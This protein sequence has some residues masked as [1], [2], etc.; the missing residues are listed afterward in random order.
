[1]AVKVCF[2]GGAR[3]GQPVDATSEKKFKAI[4]SLGEVFIIG[5]S[6][7][8]WPR[9]F[10]EHAHFYLLPKLPLPVLRYIEMSFVGPLLACWLILWHGVQVLVAQS[11]YEGFAAAV[12]KKIACCL[13]YKVVLVVE[14]HGDF[15]ESMLLQRS[16]AFVGLY[17]FLMRH[18]ARFS[19]KHADLLRAVSNSTQEQLGRQSP[20]KLIIRFPAWTDIEVFLQ[21]GINREKSSSQNILYA[22]VLTPLKGVHYLINA[23]AL[24]AKDFP[25]ARLFIVGHE[26]NKSYAAE[27]KEQVT[28]FG[29]DARV[30]FMGAMPQAEL[31]MWMRK[32]CVFVLPSVSEGLGRVVMEAMAT[33]TPVIGS[34]VGGIPDVVKD[35]ATGF[36]VRPGDEKVLTEKIQWVL[37]YPDKTQEMGHHARAFAERFFSTEVYV[38]GYRQIFTVAQASLAEDSEHAASAL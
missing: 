28:R 6:R 16:I 29:L 12:A 19:L 26:K 23:F 37:E 36:L 33:G 4:K 15:E 7:D 21:D 14:S 22:G 38:D 27:L 13:R 1:M 31:A 17:R 10:T 25:Q 32:A 24:I 8:L 18:A 3:Y 20:G 34:K 11:P 30:Q 5:F 9:S 35:G 2:L